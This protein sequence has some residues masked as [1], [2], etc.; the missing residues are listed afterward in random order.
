[1]QGGRYRAVWGVFLW[2]ARVCSFCWDEQAR[3]T[4]Q[5][6]VRTRGEA[7]FIYFL[8]SLLIYFCCYPGEALRAGVWVLTV[9]DF[10]LIP[11]SP[12]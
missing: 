6:Q 7:I 9:D 3:L 2:E 12:P 5:K 8:V 10:L 4:H 11:G 1:M